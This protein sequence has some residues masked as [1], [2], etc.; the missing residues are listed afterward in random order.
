MD[1]EEKKNDETLR[2]G[3]IS[4]RS[5]LLL[6]HD[7]FGVSAFVLVEDFINPAPTSYIGRSLQR[8]SEVTPS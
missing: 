7:P 8:G 3:V 1:V 2:N 6:Q 5:I 4:H